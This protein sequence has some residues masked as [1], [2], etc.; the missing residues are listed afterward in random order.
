M[1]TGTQ[2]STLLMKQTLKLKGNLTNK[3]LISFAVYVGSQG[4]VPA[5]NVM[6]KVAEKVSTLDVQSGLR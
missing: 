4:K 5:S 1:S 6:R 2:I 3:D